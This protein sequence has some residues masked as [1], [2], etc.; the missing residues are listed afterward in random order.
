MLKD[1]AIARDRQS[2]SQPGVGDIGP[3]DIMGV[4]VNGRTATAAEVSGGSQNA[5]AGIGNAPWFKI[6]E[7]IAI[8]GMGITAIEVHNL[9]PQDATNSVSVTFQGH[10]VQVQ[11]YNAPGHR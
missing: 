7:G 10:R 9:M 3:N 6:V 1:G 2:N 8:D 11:R 4:V 5:P